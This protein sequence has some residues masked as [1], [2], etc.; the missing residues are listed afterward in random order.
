[1]SAQ[2]PPKGPAPQA[3]GPVQARSVPAATAATPVKMRKVALASFMGTVIEFYDFGIYATAAALVFADAFFPALGEHAGT[4]VSYA[5]LGVAF[6]ARPLGSILFGH[7]G[8]RLGRKRTLIVTMSLMGVSTVLIGLLPT[9]ASIGVVAPIVL[10]VLRIAQGLAAGGEWAGAALFTTEHSP[11]ARRGFWAMFTNLGGA[12][13]N[14]LALGT[15]LITGLYMSDETFAAWGWRLPFILSILLIV[16]GLYV[17]LRIEE[18]PAFEAEAK[19]RRA[20]DGLP[21]KEALVHQWKEVLLGAGAL[22]MAFSLGYI[23]IGF[24]TNYGTATLHLP[25]PQVLGAGMFGNLL[26][27][28]AIIAGGMLT[29]RFGRRPVLLI[30]NVAGIPWALILFPLLDTASLGAF[31]LGMSVTFLIAGVGF[32][33]A[34]SFLSELF[35][36]RYRYTAAGLS[37]SLAGVLGGAIPPLV[38]A[39]LIGSY[40]GFVFGIF[41]AAYCLVGLGCTLALRETRHREL[42]EVTQSEEKTA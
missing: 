18:T 36:T 6:V 42:T 30:A 34:G 23:G 41:L 16:V 28:L 3:L 1:M 10:V 33:V 39:S 32:G 2:S 8:D 24:L 20:G 15:F 22:V 31:W 17:R 38:A 21:F 35:H 7:F 19:R 14:I 27:C 29:D 9:A 13:A 25:R 37:Y 5:T 4:V 26:N 40:G 12:F 11:K